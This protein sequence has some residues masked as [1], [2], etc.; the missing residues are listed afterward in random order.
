[1]TQRAFESKK[2]YGA[3]RDRPGHPGRPEPGGG[4]MER[5]EALKD[6]KSD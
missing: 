2:N 1:M 5:M 3:L 6:G 4:V